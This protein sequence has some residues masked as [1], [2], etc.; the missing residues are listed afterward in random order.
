M[1]K[2]CMLSRMSFRRFLAPELSALRVVL[3]VA[4][5]YAAVAAW[6]WIIS[7]RM[8]F[9]PP[10]P[11]Y[12]DTPDVLRLPTADGER[13]AAVYFPNLAATYTLL[14][15]HGNAEDL[16]WV[17]PSLP[18][19]RD[20]GFGVF[21]YDYR[22]YGLSE[23]RPSERHVYADIDAAYEYLTRELRVPPARIIL[24]G[25]SLGAG[26]AVDLAARR[27]VGGLILESPFLTAFRVMTRVPVFPFDKFRNVDKIG[28]VRC[29]VLIMHGEADEIVPLWHGQRL[30][31]RVPGP[32]MFVSVPGAH[33][34]D[35]MWVAGARY[36]SALRDFEALL[37]A[38]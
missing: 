24:Y 12:R 11:S 26:A 20:L 22:G 36:A 3:S 2:S 34:N 6:V 37:R 35:F 14:L 4:F 31:E 32:K 17:L 18:P 25:R 8:I 19:L 13:I 21:A 38:R 28:R 9:L 10:A 5:V 15:S 23:G 30:F 27:A 29:P 1:Q 7:D 33:H 16:G